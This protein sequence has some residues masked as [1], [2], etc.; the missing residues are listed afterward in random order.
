MLGLWIEEKGKGETRT[1][2]QTGGLIQWTYLNKRFGS[3]CAFERNFSSKNSIIKVPWL[4]PFWGRK[5]QTWESR[6]V[7]IWASG[8][9]NS[10]PFLC[11]LW[12][13]PRVWPSSW[14]LL[15]CYKWLCFPCL[16]KQ[17]SNLPM[18][19]SSACSMMKFCC[20]CTPR[21]WPIYMQF[22]WCYQI[23]RITPDGTTH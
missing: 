16:N 8:Q 20:S 1:P 5:D 10:K 21:S 22:S 17:C 4:P 23:V 15:C 14:G 12:Q 13:Y 11:M 3:P 6:E 19:H 9:A 7:A 18:F 2:E